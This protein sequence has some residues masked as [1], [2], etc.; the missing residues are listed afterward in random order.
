MEEKPFERTQPEPEILPKSVLDAR[1]A[2]RID[3]EFETLIVDNY[4][5][6]E[7]FLH[8]PEQ[9]SSI[10]T[11]KDLGRVALSRPRRALNRI[12]Q[13]LNIARIPRIRK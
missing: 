2:Q 6:A 7:T 1:E 8:S 13:S 10:Q 11:Q 12:E 3:D 4:P 9:S 5:D